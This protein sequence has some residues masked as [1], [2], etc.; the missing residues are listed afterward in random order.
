[1]AT[2]GA[3]SP[4]SAATFQSN[5]YDD[6]DWNTPSNIL[7]DNGVTTAPTTL[8]TQNQYTWVIRAYNFNFSA[9]PDGSIINGVTVRSNH[10]YQE[11]G[12][13]TYMAVYYA[14]LLNGTT[15]LGNNKAASPLV[16]SS[17]SGFVQTIGSSSDVWG[18]TLTT[19]IV[20]SSAFGIGIGWRAPNTGDANCFMDY[21]S[22]EVEYTLASRS[23]IILGGKALT[24]VTLGGLVR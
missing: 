5:P 6:V 2:T 24:S 4:G 21:I 20:K 3:V 8:V 14:Y 16:P 19:A 9:I 11:R 15:T 10:W 22:M 13:G 18:A 17:S 1:M 7:S 23:G 12:N